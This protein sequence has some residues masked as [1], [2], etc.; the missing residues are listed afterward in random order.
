MTKTA[1]WILVLGLGLAC[2]DAQELDDVEQPA[3]VLQLDEYDAEAMTPPEETGEPEDVEKY[4]VRISHGFRSDIAPPTQ[5]GQCVNPQIA[6]STQMCNFPTDRTVTMQC[7]LFDTVE[8]RT[9]CETLVDQEALALADQYGSSGWSFG[10]V[11]SG[12]DITITDGTVQGA[13]T[14]SDIRGYVNLAGNNTAATPEAA[15]YN[16]SYRRFGNANII[17]DWNRI[18]A[19]F[20]VASGDNLRVKGHSIG[21]AT[22]MAVGLGGTTAATNRKNS[23]AITAGTAKSIN[24]STAD[25]CRVKN[26]DPSSP[27]LITISGSCP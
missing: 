15:P 12:G 16:G 9:L 18:D 22:S 7:Q 3:R 1:L 27:N 19:N 13:E 4:T 8:R 14:L 10:R 20:T 2:G 5:G 21:F 26:Y 23:N 17:V 24:H 11:T 25:Q 6:V